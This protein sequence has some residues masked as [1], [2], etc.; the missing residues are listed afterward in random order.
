MDPRIREG[1]QGSRQEIQNC[2]LLLGVLS[3]F[4]VK[5]LGNLASKEEGFATDK[6]GN[7]EKQRRF[8]CHGRTR[9]YTEMKRSKEDSFATDEHGKEE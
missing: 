7:E 9:N 2:L 3:V 5:V 8:I 1:D 6:H 4:A